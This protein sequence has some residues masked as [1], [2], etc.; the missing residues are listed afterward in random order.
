MKCT[1][2]YLFSHGVPFTGVNK[3]FLTERE[4]MDNTISHWNHAK[5]GYLYTT[6]LT[7]IG[8]NGKKVVSPESERYQECLFGY[9][10]IVH[11]DTCIICTF[12]LVF[13]HGNKSRAEQGGPWLEKVV[14]C[15]SQTIKFQF[16]RT[17][18]MHMKFCTRSPNNNMHWVCII[19][20]IVR[21]FPDGYF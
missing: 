17:R 20:Y 11:T 16:K 18:L 7:R 3:I 21:K 13:S 15:K 12:T 2:R 5:P 1:P 9:S 6:T 8:S 4:W 10:G 19:Q 14:F